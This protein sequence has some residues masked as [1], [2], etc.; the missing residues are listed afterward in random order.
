MLAV[1]IDLNLRQCK[2]IYECSE[3]IFFKHINK[4]GLACVWYCVCF[5]L[6]VFGTILKR[7]QDAF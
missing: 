2:G 4:T 3:M 6:C 1:R 5:R 7:F